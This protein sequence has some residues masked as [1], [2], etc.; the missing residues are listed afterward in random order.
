M[1][2]HNFRCN[3]GKVNEVNIYSLSALRRKITVYPN[4]K[5]LT[6]DYCNCDVMI[7]NEVKRVCLADAEQDGY[8]FEM[9]RQR[10]MKELRKNEE[11]LKSAGPLV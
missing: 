3:R 7:D 10:A 4:A 11:M 8:E 9:G 1:R 5:L 2:R 6:C